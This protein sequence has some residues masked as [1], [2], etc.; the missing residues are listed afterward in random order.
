[1]WEQVAA[2][3]TRCHRDLSTKPGALN[4][5]LPLHSVPTGIS[6]ICVTPV[7]SAMTEAR[8]SKQECY[9]LAH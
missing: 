4:E 5:S 8:G 6:R 1:M 9:E 7:R 2:V 3:V